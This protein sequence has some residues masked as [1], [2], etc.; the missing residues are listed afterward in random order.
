LVATRPEGKILI[1]ASDTVLK[2]DTKN[3]DIPVNNGMSD[4]D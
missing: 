1:M 2:K 4:K 3:A